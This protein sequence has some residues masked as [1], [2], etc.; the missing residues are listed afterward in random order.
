MIELGNGYFQGIQ[1]KQKTNIKCGEGSDA[2]EKREVVHQRR[3]KVHSKSK[4][5]QELEKV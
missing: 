3:T 1:L 4:E 2:K 5:Q